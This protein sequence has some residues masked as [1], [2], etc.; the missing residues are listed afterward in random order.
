MKQVLATCCNLEEYPFKIAILII[1]WAGEDLD[2][3]SSMN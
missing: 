2:I 1:G 3:G